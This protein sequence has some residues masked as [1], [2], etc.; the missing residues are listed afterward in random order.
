MFG[1]QGY[2]TAMLADSI[3]AGTIGPMTKPDQYLGD[4]NMTPKS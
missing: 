2:K 1:N 3:H 4:S